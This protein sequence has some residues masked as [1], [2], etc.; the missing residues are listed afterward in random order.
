[1]TK[2]DPTASDGPRLKVV[3]PLVLV[4][5]GAIC[6]LLNFRRPARESMDSIAL[7]TNIPAAQAGAGSSNQADRRSAYQQLGSRLRP[8]SHRTQTVGAPIVLENERIT[9]TAESSHTAGSD[10]APAVA[11]VLLDSGI[12]ITGKVS[13][14][15][16]PPPEIPIDMS[17]DAR[18]AKLQKSPPTT[19]HYVVGKEGGLANVFV[20]IKEGLRAR[21]FPISTNIARMGPSNCFFEPYMAGVQ[22]NQKLSLRSADDTTHTA[23]ITPKSG[24]GNKALNISLPRRGEPREHLFSAAETLVQIRCDTHPWEFGYVGVVE[25]PFFA[26]TDANG[27]FRLPSGMTPGRYTLEAIHPKAGAVSQ[28]FEI[29]A[30]EKATVDFTLQA[31]AAP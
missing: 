11:A 2:P 27:E 18:C 8:A 28:E 4:C 17:S 30:G 26:I 3:V 16:T 1:M 21:R 15:G 20:Y 14:M 23:H 25:H 19:R 31:P 13:L 10:P 6:L 29:R 7:K 12:E 22:V 24:S 5:L 9:T